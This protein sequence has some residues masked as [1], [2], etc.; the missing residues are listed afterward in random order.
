MYLLL[1]CNQLRLGEPILQCRGFHSSDEGFTQMQFVDFEVDLEQLVDEVQHPPPLG[2]VLA[3]PG[4]RGAHPEAGHDALARLLQGL[5]GLPL[6]RLPLLL[7]CLHSEQPQVQTHVVHN[8]QKPVIIPL[9]SYKIMIF[10][11]HICRYW[12]FH[13]WMSY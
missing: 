2:H 13:G 5:P 8:R 11:L 6:A 10:T 1:V 4:V 7:V 12:T 3:R 9:R